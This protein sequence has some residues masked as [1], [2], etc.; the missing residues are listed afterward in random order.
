VRQQRIFARLREGWSH[1]EIAQ[2]ETLS[3]E[4]VRQIVAAALDDREADS[5]LDHSRLQITRLEPAL[6][7]AAERVAAGELRAVDR[8]LKVLERLAKYE[9]TVRTKVEYEDAIRIRAELNERE[10]F[11]DG[12]NA[13]DQAAED[14]FDAEAFEADEQEYDDSKFFRY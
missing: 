14:G 5:G 10:A 2:A 9:H 7:L 4:R 12:G 6:R 11:D 8:L 1:D 3:R 13:E